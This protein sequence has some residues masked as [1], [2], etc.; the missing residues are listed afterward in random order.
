MVDGVSLVTGG[1]PVLVGVWSC[2]TVLVGMVDGVPLV[3]GGGPML[4]G[5]WSCITVLVSVVD[6]VPLVGSGVDV[7]VGIGSTVLALLVVVDPVE[8]CEIDMYMWGSLFIRTYLLMKYD[9]MYVTVTSERLTTACCK[10][11]VA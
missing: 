5:V 4:V 7:A 11:Y 10:K 6:G 8:M 2:V 3:T 1:D 9:V